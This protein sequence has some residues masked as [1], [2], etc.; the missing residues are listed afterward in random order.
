MNDFLVYLFFSTGAFILGTIPVHLLSQRFLKTQ[1]AQRFLNAPLLV[2]FLIRV[3]KGWI[4]VQLGATLILKYFPVQLEVNLGVWLICLFAVL[5][6]CL[7]PWVRIDQDKSLSLA[8]GGL[9]IIAPLTAFSSLIAFVL[10]FFATSSQPRAR[11]NALFVAFWAQVIAYPVGHYLWA[12]A[13]LLFVLLV[14]HESDLDQILESPQ[15]SLS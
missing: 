4:I 13:A 2:G 1:K 15:Q 5:G 3:M 12:G 8:V 14:R 7:T 6:D 9:I 10:T 11:L